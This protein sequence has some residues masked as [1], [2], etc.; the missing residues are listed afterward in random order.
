MDVSLQGLIDAITKDSNISICIHDIS[1]ILRAAPLAVRQSNTMHVK[2]FCDAVK[3]TR[4]GMRLCVRC[5][6]IANRRSIREQALFV[7][8]CP[9][10]M[11]EIVRPV[12]VGGSTACIIYLGSIVRDRALFTAMTAKA[13]RLCGLDPARLAGHLDG[14]QYD[15]DA[16]PYIEMANLIAGIIALLYERYKP[17]LNEKNH[18]AVER[19]KNY[20]AQYYYQDLSVADVA[21]QYYVNPSYIGRVFKKET[22]MSFSRFLS[23]IRVQKARELISTTDR[24]IL[25]IALS[26]GFNSVTY[27]NKIFKEITGATPMEHRRVAHCR[28]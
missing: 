14:L 12:V 10:G 24:T 9:F 1:G 4:R 28:G 27:F 5:K 19:F 22:G 6:D 15:P 25:D 16:A 13:A 21:R 26:V 23:G 8:L 18:W 7:G 2:P 17:D 3:T 20:A 11:T